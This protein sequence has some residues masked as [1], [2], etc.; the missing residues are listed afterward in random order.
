MP[1]PLR[2]GQDLL[3]QGIPGVVVPCLRRLLQ[4]NGVAHRLDPHEAQTSRKRFILRPRDVFG[5]HLVSQRRAFLVAGCHD[6]L[7]HATGDLR[8]RSLGGTDKP[9]ETRALQDQ[10]HQANPTGTHFGPHQL[11]RQDQAMQEG[12]TGDAGK[13]R[14]D[15]WTLVEALLGRLPCLQRGAR[16]RKHLGGLPLGEAL[17]FEIVILLQEVSALDA[18]PTWVAIIVASLRLLDYRAHRYL[19]WPFFAFGV[20][21]AKDGEVALWFQPFVVPSLCLSGAVL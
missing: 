12:K 13:K 11:G 5:G 19:L 3:H 16:H 15:S 21:M 10:T 4:E 2:P 6:G 7:F 1:W 20:V 9:I 17:G 8:L 18:L 14:S